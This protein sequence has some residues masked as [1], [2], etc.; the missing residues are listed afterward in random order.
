MS[1]VSAPSRFAL[2]VVGIGGQG[3]LTVSRLVGEAAM[4]GGVDA[5]L[6]QLHGMSQRGGSVQSSVL[7]GPGRTS[8]VAAGGA[9]VVL[10]LEPLEVVRALPAMGPATV[11]VTSTGRIVPHTLTQQGRDYPEL[12][13]LLDEVRDRAARLIEL[14]AP[15]LARAAGTGRALNSVMLGAL[16]GLEVLPAAISDE[17]LVAAIESRFPPGFRDIN[18]RAFAFGREAVLAA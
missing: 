11:V 13:P 15:A 10:G 18:R 3:V 8:F 16:A 4:A 2:L 5:V 14:D 17:A 12:A 6:G 7:L 1:G 9:R